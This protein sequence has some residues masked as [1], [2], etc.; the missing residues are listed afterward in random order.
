[1]NQNLV[2]QSLLKFFE[3]ISKD[4]EKLKKL[5]SYEDMDK[6][7]EYAISE[8]KGDFKK[9]EFEECLNSII[10]LSEKIS[11]GELEPEKIDEETLSKISGGAEE[12]WGRN[13]VLLLPSII[14]LGVTIG[15][16]IREDKKAK[17]EEEK[18]NDPNHIKDQE[19]EREYRIWQYRKG[20]EE[21]RRYLATPTDK[22]K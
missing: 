13:I 15:T 3:D 5:F 18:R 12:T 20:I 19:L 7:Y 4:E 16:W 17:K 9:K 10:N 6:M 8:S 21:A 2:N 22:N 1:M 14:T 11:E